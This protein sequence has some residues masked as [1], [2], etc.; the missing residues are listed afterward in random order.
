MGAVYGDSVMMQ[1]ADQLTVPA[2]HAGVP[3]LSLPGGLDQE[4][5]PIG[6]QLL[7]PDFS[8]DV[9]LRIGRAFERVTADDDWRQVKPKVLR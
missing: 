3:G 5:L 4:G 1:F 8:E 2:N 7:G 9:L 6:I